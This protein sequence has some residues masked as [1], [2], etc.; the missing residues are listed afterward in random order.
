MSRFAVL[1]LFLPLAAC[2]DAPAAEDPRAVTASEQRALDEAAEM[3]EERR[4]PEP[5]QTEAVPAVGSSQ[6][7]N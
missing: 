4:P 6:A 5:V 2:G 3:L 1:T 7:G